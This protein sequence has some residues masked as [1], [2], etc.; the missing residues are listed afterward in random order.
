MFS[1]GISHSF[2]SFLNPKPYTSKVGGGEGESDVGVP[3]GRKDDARFF[4]LRR[5]PLD[6]DPGGV[7]FLIAYHVGENAGQVARRARNPHLERN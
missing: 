5:L 3:L 1:S 2:I 7:L 4:G 6:K